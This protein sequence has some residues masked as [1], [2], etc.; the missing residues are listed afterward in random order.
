M[1]Y[2]RGACSVTRWEGKSNGSVF[3]RCGMGPCVNGVV[4]CSGMG[5][6]KY[7]VVVLVILRE[8]REK[9]L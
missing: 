3:E 7:F 6:R 2:L 9:I 8:I 1:R 4:W 5:E